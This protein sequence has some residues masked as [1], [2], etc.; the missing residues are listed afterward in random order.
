MKARSYALLALMGLALAFGVARFE[1]FPGYLDSDYYFGGG[2]QLAAGK[3]FTEPYLWNYLDDPSGLP[4]TSHSYWMPLSS[5]IAAAGL[6]LT[7][8]TNY[9]AGRLGFLLLAALVPVVTAALAY[10]FTCRASLAM[11]SG[12]LAVFAVYYVPFLPVSDNYGP[13]LV[14]GGLYFLAMGWRKPA[15]MLALGVISGLLTLA[16]SDGLLW[17]A[18]TAVI[19]AVRF[20]SDRRLGAAILGGTLALAGFIVVTGPWFWHTYSVYGT[21]LAPGGSHL[22]WLKSYD[23]TFIYPASQLTFQS[24]LAQGLKAIVNAR[25]WALGWNLENAFAAQGEIFLL[26]FILVG[27]WMYRNDERV[28]VA[29]LGWA[30]LLFVMTVIFP[31]AGARGG[32]F[33]SGAAV[34]PMWWTLAPAGLDRAISAARKRRLFT[35][36]AFT[37]FQGALVGIAILMTGVILSIRVVRGWGD[38]EQDY[39]KIESFLQSQGIQPEDIIMVGNPPGYYLMTGRQAIVVPLADEQTMATVASRY[40]ARYLVIESWGAS[41]PIDSVYQNKS[42]QRFPYLGNIDGTHIFRFVP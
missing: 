35:P 37:I 15:S 25:L 31:F 32:F 13:Y 30:A 28:R 8:S 36:Q 7:H 10:Q 26:P 11:T 4:H 38:G 17:L 41:G 19:V 29:I 5:L 34:Q 24:W 14:L 1:H 40:G 42:S 27:A 18:M 3:G 6:W 2:L 39:P 20:W 21:L 22:L 33:H 16:R 12:L 23:E 9:E